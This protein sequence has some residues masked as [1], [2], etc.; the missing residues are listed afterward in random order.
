MQLITGKKDIQKE[1]MKHIFNEMQVLQSD[2]D[3][4]D[5]YKIGLLDISPNNSIYNGK[6]FLVDPGNYMIKDLTTIKRHV[7]PYN[8]NDDK[9]LLRKWNEEKINRL[10]DMLLFSQNP[11]IDSY[12]YRLIIQFFNKEKQNKKINYN[13]EVFKEFFDQ[14]LTV[15]DSIDKFIHKH[16]KEDIKERLWYMSS[17]ER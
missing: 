1:L 15:K 4:L 7:D 11:N 2:L 6:I 9:L 8:L 10:F 3:L 13:L 17:L 14:E 5:K 12:Q 16:I